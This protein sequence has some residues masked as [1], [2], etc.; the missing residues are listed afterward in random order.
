[1]L[2]YR[3][4]LSTGQTVSESDRRVKTHDKSTLTPLTNEN[5][6]VTSS[7]GGE[8]T[9]SQSS[10]AS[11][12]TGNNNG[13]AA[14]NFTGSEGS[15][16]ASNNTGSENT[17]PVS[18]NTV[19][20]ENIAGHIFDSGSHQ[21]SETA[22]KVPD[23]YI[24]VPERFVHKWDSKVLVYNRNSPLSTWYPAPFTVK[25][26][27]YICRQ[28]Y[29][30][31]QEAL[32][33]ANQ[34]TAE[35]ILQ[36]TDPDEI[37]RTEIEVN[38]KE[39]WARH[40]GQFL[41]KAA[42][43]QF[44]YNSDLKE[45]LLDTGDLYL[46]HVAL[47]RLF[48]TGVEFESVLALNTKRWNGSNLCGRVLMQI[49]DNLRRKLVIVPRL[50]ET[51]T[52]EVM[53][54]GYDRVRSSNGESDCVVWKFD[55]AK[56]KREKYVLLPERC[57]HKQNSETFIFESRMSPLSD[58]YPAPFTVKGQMYS[59]AQQYIAHQKALLF[60]DPEAAGKFLNTTDPD[61]LS[62][63]QVEGFRR[64]KWEK[65]KEQIMID[66]AV[67]RFSQNEELLKLLYNTDDLHL[68]RMGNNR[69]YGTGITID[70]DDA[71]NK[72]RWKGE[73]RDGTALMAARDILRSQDK[74]PQIP[75]ETVMPFQGQPLDIKQ[76]PNVNNRGEALLGRRNL[77]SDTTESSG[78]H[79]SILKD[80]EI[81]R[82]DD[83]EKIL[84][85]HESDLTEE[86]ST[87]YILLP[88]TLVHRHDLHTLVYGI[89][90]PFSDLYPAQ[91]TVNGQTY[92]C[93][94][95]YS[96]H[97][98]A[99]L[100]G[101]EE[102]ARK[103]L[104]ATDPEE[105]GLYEVEEANEEKLV[106]H[107]GNI[108]CDAAFHKFSQI[109]KL[110][111]LLLS[112]DDL[113]LGFVFP[114]V[115]YGTGVYLDN[116]C[117]TDRKLWS[118]ENRCGEALMRARDMLKAEA[119]DDILPEHHT[120]LDEVT[121]SSNNE[122]KYQSV[123]WENLDKWEP[124]Q[125]IP[126][127]E[128]YIHRQN[129]KNFLY[130]GE[131]SPFSDL[132]PA[133][134]TVDG[135]TYSC[136]KQY[137]LHQKALIFR[138]QDAAENILKTT[139]PDVGVFNV[140]G[141]NKEKW[142]HFEGIILICA[143]VQKFNQN[144]QLKE[145]LLNTNDLYF[146]CMNRNLK[147]GTGM[148]IYSDKAFDR[149]MWPGENRNGEVLMTTRDLLRMRDN[150]FTEKTNSAVYSFVKDYLENKTSAIPDPVEEETVE[151][152]HHDV[153]ANRK[154]YQV[155]YEKCL[156]VCEKL[157]HRQDS[158]TLVYGQY[159]PFSDLHPAPFTVDGERFSS[160]AQ[161]IMYHKALLFGDEE[162]AEQI[163]RSRD[164]EEIISL[165][166][167][168]LKVEK[169]RQHA[170]K[171]IRD[172]YFYKFNQNPK[173]KYLLLRTEDLHL[174]EA[175]TDT[176]YGTG[177]TFDK[178]EALD[179]NHWIGENMAGK[180]LMM[181]RDTLRTHEVLP[182][183]QGSSGGDLDAVSNEIDDEEMPKGCV[184][185]WEKWIHKQNSETFIF[186][187]Q[188]SPLSDMHP[189]PFTVKG[190][191]YNCAQQYIAHQKAL[192]FKDKETGDEIL[193]TT[194]PDEITRLPVKGFNREKWEQ[195]EE[196]IFV[197]A[198]IYKFSQNEELRELLLNTGDLHLGNM[199]NNRRYGTGLMIDSEEALNKRRWKGMNRDGTALMEA[200]YIL[201]TRG[202]ITSKAGKNSSVDGWSESNR[203]QMDPIVPEPTPTNKKRAY[204]TSDSSKAVQNN[205]PRHMNESFGNP[206][207][208][209]VTENRSL[210]TRRAQSD[211]KRVELN[212]AESPMF[213]SLCPSPVKE[214]PYKQDSKTFVYNEHSPF[215]AMYP[216]EFTVNG[217]MYRSATQYI[218]HQKALLFRDQKTAE[219]IL[220]S[221]DPEEMESFKVRDFDEGKWKDH[222][223]NIIFE[224]ALHKFRQNPNLTQRLLATGRL[225][226][227]YAVTCE[228]H[229]TGVPISSP[230]ALQRGQWSGD[231]RDGEAVM[232]ARAVLWR[233]RRGKH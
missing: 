199:S 190:Q 34:E 215:S 25:G 178:T 42:T 98:K 172:A 97:Q 78:A 191:T 31:H 96:E 157:I 88:E 95:Q 49:R 210:K 179:R 155:F 147:Y 111:T 9:G 121:P 186:N 46:G 140:E 57:I 105:I 80:K 77:G 180:A 84:N 146:G 161:Y 58:R 124:G 209:R 187:G 184:P 2:I 26:Q 162:T 166:V 207:N 110:K 201:R 177:V 159:S 116:V 87:K 65:H 70:S 117:T 127:P 30:K 164:L 171:S 91:F 86:L 52:R 114:D 69:R 62:R 203:N 102:K 227:G 129:A 128:K 126:V 138:D 75:V 12:R 144:D 109:L 174:G 74:V 113:H 173:L 223:E 13:S 160:A 41:Y 141:F 10:A 228:V 182:V 212:E 217:H 148:M 220:G 213:A 3:I 66:A 60:G 183:A 231:N 122:F 200:R 134:F 229:G 93:S 168:G 170:E 45:L 11:D 181:T 131:L 32:L 112:T 67:H 38:D 35:K 219:K 22:W 119:Q 149:K 44:S 211:V 163:L 33:Y 222:M 14:S 37:G 72:E 28:Q 47:N 189:A 7:P 108:L 107:E 169:W 206:K 43:H 167:Y 101:D 56:H 15:N 176:F 48:G 152:N 24:A 197:D 156:P 99:L 115:R 73:N 153:T 18:N 132:Y 50:H 63:I 23:Q 135:Q 59:C 76:V 208:R 188:M 51:K 136:A 53:T 230:E 214:V 205:A 40:K 195:H 85:V 216:A 106:Q 204:K 175:Q 81:R 5:H 154:T 221:T 193:E 71:L 6:T 218:E 79:A 4:F 226:L 137:I 17:I 165:K 19:N 133:P 145:L 123:D 125:Y 130:C 64:E 103:V 39:K 16:A 55:T 158:D 192:L 104:Q 142:K 83:L 151:T 225:Q 224:A 61:E 118:G 150:T 20:E 36:T 196:E 202:N 143:A 1:M 139:E 8:V 194:E 92:I 21:N 198:A 29:I 82:K 120:I 54:T 68:G 94:L 90:S 100:F 89:L 185:V 233:N 232:L 27:T